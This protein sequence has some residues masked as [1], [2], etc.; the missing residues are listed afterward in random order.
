LPELNTDEQT[1]N[2]TWKQCSHGDIGFT[3]GLF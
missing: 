3:F 2:V 1:P